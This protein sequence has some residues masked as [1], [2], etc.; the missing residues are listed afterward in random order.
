MR[1]QYVDDVSVSKAEKMLEKTEKTGI[2]KSGAISGALAPD[3]SR[4]QEHAERYYESVRK[5]TTD[6]AR[7]ARNT[8]YSESEIQKIKNFIFMDAHDLGEEGVKRFDASYEMAESWQRLMDGKSI[9]PH[10]FTLLKHEIMEKSLMEQGY[11]QDEAH[12]I[13]S[14][15]YNYAKEAYKYYHG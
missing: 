7:I 8:G 12:R 13:V 10:D 4:A 15:I 6:V 2:I 1:V 11:S 9:Q 3:S 5:M 14:Q